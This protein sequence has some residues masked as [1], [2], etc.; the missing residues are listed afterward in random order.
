MWI[1]RMIWVLGQ[2]LFY[3]L[4][5]PLLFGVIYTLSHEQW[6]T[7][8]FFSPQRL[9]PLQRADPHQNPEKLRCFT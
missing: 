9:Y 2:I 4:L 6:W 5:I 8:L 3:L 1:Q 7:A